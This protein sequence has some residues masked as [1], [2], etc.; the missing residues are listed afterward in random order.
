MD[1][2]ESGKTAEDAEKYLSSRG[3]LLRAVSGYGLPTCLRMTI[4]SD[5]ENH[6]VL[7]ALQKFLDK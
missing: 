6:A 4:G 2:A 1:F 5:E 7:D 3:L